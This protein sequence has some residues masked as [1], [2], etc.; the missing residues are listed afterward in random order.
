MESQD[1]ILL[2]T[3]SLCPETARGAG[4]SRPLFRQSAGAHFQEYAPAV[5]W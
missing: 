4:V 5:G 3:K 2:I 1:R